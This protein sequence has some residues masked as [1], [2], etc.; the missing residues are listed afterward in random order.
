MEVESGFCLSRGGFCPC[1]VHWASLGRVPGVQPALSSCNKCP[2]NRAPGSSLLLS[3]RVFVWCQGTSVSL[4]ESRNTLRP[5][6]AVRVWEG[7]V[8]LVSKTMEFT[9]EA[10]LCG[11]VV[12]D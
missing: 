9:G 5:L 7:S 8:S 12:T 4:T 3:C 10:A 11:R 2:L 6:L 1:S